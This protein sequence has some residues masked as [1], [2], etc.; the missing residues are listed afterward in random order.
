[1]DPSL[2]LRWNFANVLRHTPVRL[3]S[4]VPKAIIVFRLRVVCLD[5]AFLAIATVTRA[6]AIRTQDFARIVSTTLKA[7]IAKRAWKDFTGM[8]LPE[9]RR[10][11]CVVLVLMHLRLT[12]LPLLVR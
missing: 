8:Q 5:R 1:M 11:A 3:V 2:L 7:I 4:F 12:I 10:R 6:R 9:V